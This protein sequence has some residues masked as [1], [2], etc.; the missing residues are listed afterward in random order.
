MTS[1]ARRPTFTRHA[2][3]RASV[4][5]VAAG[6]NS[7]FQ[8]DRFA[9]LAISSGSPLFGAEERAQYE[10][11]I[12]LAQRKARDF[13]SRKQYGRLG[14][15]DAKAQEVVGELALSLLRAEV[16]ERQKYPV[17]G[18]RL[19]EIIE[20]MQALTCEANASHGTSVD[21]VSEVSPPRARLLVL[22]RE[23]LCRSVCMPDADFAEA[24]QPLSSLDAAASILNARKCVA[25]YTT[26]ALMNLCKS[27]WR[28]TYSANTVPLFDDET[29][30]QAWRPPAGHARA[31]VVLACKDAFTK[32]ESGPRNAREARNVPYIRAVVNALQSLLDVQDE[33]LYA[34]ARKLLEAENRDARE[35]KRGLAAAL[36]H[37]IIVG[38][39]QRIHRGLGWH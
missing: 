30:Q 3:S 16:F 2:V 28:D 11:Q 34:V 21:D 37:P 10:Y 4:D 26:S 31:V 5:G 7:N 1:R 22:L 23:V 15:V 6:A 12:K 17:E 33:T 27:A 39:L 25:W 36:R 24:L 32:L 35:I 13:L 29:V 9:I 19:A 38:A 20:H 8:A 18:L 14:D